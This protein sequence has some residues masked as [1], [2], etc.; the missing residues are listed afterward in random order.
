MPTTIAI[1][2]APLLQVKTPDKLN[3]GDDEIEL[4]IILSFKNSFFFQ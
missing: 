2:N 4:D 3:H 1:G